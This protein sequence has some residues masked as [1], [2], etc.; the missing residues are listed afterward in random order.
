MHGKSLVMKHVVVVAALAVCAGS[1]FSKGPAKEAS[2]A[3]AAL[4]S[5]KAAQASGQPF[6]QYRIVTNDAEQV[7][8]TPEQAI[9]LWGPRCQRAQPP[10]SASGKAATQKTAQ[11]SLPGGG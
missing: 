3:C 8:S 11:A 6:E 1:A 2:P 7:I 5:A 10:S 4:Q 9:E